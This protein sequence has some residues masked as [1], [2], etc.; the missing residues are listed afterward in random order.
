M[1]ILKLRL[2]NLNSLAGSWEIDFTSPA[3]S[4]DGIFA[5]TGPTGAG[6]TTIL[7]AL[8]LALY[9]CTPRLDRVNQS[10]N[11]IMSRHQGECSAEVEFAT[12]QGRYLC[13]WGQHRSRKKADGEL[14]APKRELAC[15]STGKI[16]ASSIK[17]VAAKVEEIT[18]MDFDRFTRSMLL[19][20]GGFAA[21]LQATPDERSP[22]LEQITGTELY[23]RISI[24]VHERCKVENDRQKQLEER[25]AAFRLLTL[26]EEEAL[27]QELAGLRGTETEQKIKL[28]QFAA[29]LA[30]LK[31]LAVLRQELAGI[32]TEQAGLAMTQEQFAASEQ[33]LHLAGQALLLAGDYAALAAQRRQQADD[34][35]AAEILRRSLPEL[36]A[37]L[38]AAD[39]QL[40]RSSDALA[41]SRTAQEQGQNIIRQVRELD[42]LLQE[43]KAALK[44]QDDDCAELRRKNADDLQNC[45][46]HEQ[47]ISRV[48]AGQQQSA[49]YLAAHQADERLLTELTGL[50]QMLKQLGELAGRHDKAKLACAQAEKTVVQSAQL[51]QSKAEELCQTDMQLADAKSGRAAAEK[52][53]EHLLQG[54]RVEELRQEQ[55]S[56]VDLVGLLLRLDAL[57]KD[58]A[59]LHEQ[60]TANAVDRSK[61]AETLNALRQTRDAARQEE[62]TRRAVA[63][64]ASRVR[65]L[66][67]Q[68]QRLQAGQ[69]CPLC[70]SP[71]HPFAQGDLPLLDEAELAAQAAAAAL[72]QAENE[73]AKAGQEEVRLEQT[74]QHLSERLEE[75]NTAAQALQQQ[76]ANLCADLSLASE[77][78]RLTELE[79]RLSANKQAVQ[80]ADVLMET[81]K[82]IGKVLD[83]RQIAHAQ[84]TQAAEKAAA[85]R[86]Q[87]ATERQRL[88]DQQ[89][90]LTQELERNR[91]QAQADLAVYGIAELPLAGLEQLALALT[92][93]RDAWQRHQ[94]QSVA[95]E[96]EI[97]GL[98]TAL[99]V[100]RAGIDHR[101][102]QLDKAEP[103]L[104][105]L[106]QDTELLADKRAALF[107]DKQPN[108]E[109]RRL[110]EAV[111]TAEKATQQAQERQLQTAKQLEQQNV[112]ITS[113]EAVAAERAEP[114]RQQ[115]DAF[116][117]RLRA[118]GFADEAAWQ[119]AQLTEAD[120][121]ALSKQ[122]E[123]LRT[124]Q[125]QLAERRRDRSARL[126]DEEQ[127]SL[128]D[129]SPE[130]LEAQ[131]AALAAVCRETTE[132]IGSLN[133]RLLDNQ[134]RRGQQSGLLRELAAQQVE[135]L[136]W[137]QLDQLI[138]HSEGKKYR[139]FAQGL[140]FEQMVLHANR[141]LTRMNDRY[142]LVRDRNQPLELNVVDAWQ[143]DEVR[144]AKNLSG[145]ESFV[146]SLALALGLSSMVG[147]K[148]ESL[149]L[150][151]GF[152][153]LDDEALTTA[154]DSL[155]EL[156]REGRLIGVISHVA[157]LKERIAC[158]IEVKPG[159]GGRSALKG[160]GVRRL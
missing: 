125:A 49:A 105:A 127:L 135:C 121:A 102:A 72:R 79:Q 27:R 109:E 73:L 26:E 92:A 60:Q 53:L 3:F 128:T 101:N 55:I 19:A 142:Q 13:F 88:A 118:D 116:A 136:R 107:A 44:K 14:Q 48:Q 50:C 21:F 15:G 96:K 6:K 35:N 32:S 46:R 77:H 149:F 80:S 91:Q 146:V 159:S 37:A 34:L 33:R 108:A 9:G 11:E 16:L 17:E 122:A 82:Q 56:L 152:G 43:K 137:K 83:Q 57:T 155:A 84:A 93:R 87:A 4:G 1:R 31:R 132:R 71:D 134:E 129:L 36:E 112:L 63:V 100:L 8:C 110:A 139:N 106:R 123:D 97:A 144:S 66:E 75:K 61:L 25:V 69:P 23:S 131:Q 98:H 12:E 52:E 64:F 67:E 120:R 130:R 141:Q 62:E 42:V 38:K 89:T 156:R 160:P 7:D 2:H 133:H 94:Q 150:D 45:G 138:G 58:I 85:V 151:E 115:D 113:R 51:W 104:Q 59:E 76:T 81:I 117:A 86:D 78:I 103:P 24:R 22:I 157:A 54:R 29:D 153:T 30:W 147:G 126:A 95:A 41:A 40:A 158:Q 99:K 18:G 65:S 10:G 114:L 143:A 47:E 140:T 28:D 124:R 90:E 5:I 154:L 20:Q 70:G 111:S 119:A 148:V 39:E 74:T 145:G 68:R